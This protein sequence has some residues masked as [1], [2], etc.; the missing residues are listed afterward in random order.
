MSRSSGLLRVLSGGNLEVVCSKDGNYQVVVDNH[1]WLTS[2][3][4][5]FQVPVHVLGFCHVFNS[6][7]HHKVIGKGQGGNGPPWR[8]RG[9]Y[10]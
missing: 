6:G 4:S 1:L 9:D 3:P 7:L 2:A 10:L 5:Y 8:R